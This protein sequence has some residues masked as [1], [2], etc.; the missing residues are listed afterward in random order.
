MTVLLI[1][2]LRRQKGA[3]KAFLIKGLVVGV[4][5]LT[6]DRALAFFLTNGLERYFGLDVPAEVLLIGHSH[7]VLGID[8]VALEKRLDVPVAKYARQGANVR[9]RHTMIRHYL[10]RQPESVK[11]IVYGVSAGLFTPQGLSTNSYRLFF[12]FMS[13]GAVSEHIRR[14]GASF[15]ER[16]LRRILHTARF[17]EVTLGLAMRGFTRDWRNFKRGTVD[18][19][20]LRLQVAKGIGRGI[21][22]DAAEIATFEETLRLASD[23]G[24]EVILV[25]LPTVDMVN[26]S[27]PDT[28]RRAIA[29]FETYAAGND[30]VRF[31]N[32]NK[33]FANRYN[34]FFD[35]QHLNVEGQKEA[36]GVL[37]DTI[38]DARRPK[39][40]R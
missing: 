33:Q 34:L 16:V 35:W 23:H 29:M 18:L 5:V 19:K 27:H 6:G 17:S 36:T 32:L 9:D 20:R 12:P 2:D 15:G 10:S 26:D 13:D 22:F 37:A 30:L 11:V 24:I 31:I 40:V 7:T 14:A 28:Y 8:K 21:S 39:Q 1:D 25:Y 3:L 4:L 38:E